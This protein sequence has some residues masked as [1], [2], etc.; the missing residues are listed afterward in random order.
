[1]CADS[2]PMFKKL[3]PHL[4]Y[5]RLDYLREHFRLKGGPAHRA[6]A[7]THALRDLM[8]LLD[9]SQLATALSMLQA[10]AFKF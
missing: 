2:L 8:R 4:K 10:T 1:M 6:A 7:D 3:H 5:F 9:E